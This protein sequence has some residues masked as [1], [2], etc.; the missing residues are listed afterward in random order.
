M[1]PGPIYYPPAAVC[2]RSS[3]SSAQTEALVAGYSSPV[4]P[5]LVRTQEKNFPH[6]KELMDELRSRLAANKLPADGKS[7]TD[8]NLTE[9]ENHKKYLDRITPITDR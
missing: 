8:M 4:A 5:K 6:A 7:N 9:E 3:S 2:H 1:P